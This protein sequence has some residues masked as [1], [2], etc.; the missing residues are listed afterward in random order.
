MRDKKYQIESDNRDL[1]RPSYELKSSLKEQIISHFVKVDY[2]EPL[3]EGF[4]RSVKRRNN[5]WY[6]MVETL[7][8]NVSI[9]E[10]IKKNEYEKLENKAHQKPL[11]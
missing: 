4:Y 9:K 11:R 10:N 1:N 8:D 7:F 3:E 2:V 5:K 6:N